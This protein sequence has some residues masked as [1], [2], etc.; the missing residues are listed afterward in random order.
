MARAH[1][2]KARNFLD[3]LHYG[4]EASRAAYL[5][6]LNA[7]QALIFTRDGRATRTHRGLRTSF[8]RLAKDDPSIDPEFVGFLGRAYRFKEIAD[9]GMDSQAVVTEAEAQEMIDI[10]ARFIDCIA[11]I[12]A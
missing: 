7:A 6:S 10:A 8:A 4:D 11:G 12:L 2:A 3:V 1:L 5:A 9:Y